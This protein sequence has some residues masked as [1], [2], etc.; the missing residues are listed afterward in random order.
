MGREDLT[1]SSQ[2]K[3]LAFSKICNFKMYFDEDTLQLWSWILGLFCGNES[4]RKIAVFDGHTKY[5]WWNCAKLFVILIDWNFFRFQ[6]QNQ[7]GGHKIEE[8][9][10]AAGYLL[11]VL[12]IA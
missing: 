7:E 11:V 5:Q 8:G 3:S 2:K 6:N 12:K 9:L 4:T 10:H 1:S